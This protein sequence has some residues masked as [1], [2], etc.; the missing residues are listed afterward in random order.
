MLTLISGFSFSVAPA[1]ATEAGIIKRG[2]AV[3]TGFSGTKTDKDVP[4]DVHPLDRTFINLGGSSAQIFDLSVL[5][6]G[7]RGQ[8]ADVPSKLQIKAADVGQVF[9][10]T[11]DDGN[12]TNAPNAYLTATSL[13]GLNLVTKSASGKVERLLKGA[14]DAAWM[15]GQF[16][17]DKGGTPGSVWKVD[18]VTGAT[19][20][21]ATIKTY[22]N[23]NAGAGLGNITFDPK[24]RLLFVSDLESGMIHS[25]A[26]NGKERDIFDH[27][28]NGRKSQGLDPIAFDETRRMDITSPSFN[29]EDPA[30]WGY[31]D[32]RRRTF[33]VAVNAGRLY[34]SVAEGP[35]VWSVSIDDDGDFGSDARIELEVKD[36]ASAISDILFDGSGMLFLS[37]RGN[38][39]GSYDY[40]S[41]AT[42]QQS[43]VLRYKWDAKESRWAAVPDEYA[44]GMAKDFR[45]TQGGIASNYGYDKFGNIDFGKCRQTLW[46]TGEHLRELTGGVEKVSSGGARIVHGLQ[47]NY[48]S[49][50]RPANEPPFETWFTDYDGRDG[51]KDAFGHIGDVAIFAPCNPGAS[52]E[53]S[54]RVE[55]AP[56]LI[57]VD[58]PVDVPGLIINKHCLPGAIGGMIRCAITVTN[59][60][61]ALPSEDVK[62]RDVTRTLIGPGA[63]AIV[64]IAAYATATPAILCSSVPSL[65]FACTI[66]ALLLAPGLSSGFDVFIDTHDL[67]IAGN[68]GF[69]NCA[70]IHHPDGWAKACS[71]GGTDIVVEKIGPGFCLPGAT[72][73][74]GLKIANMGTM[75]FDG[76][77]LLAD[78]MFVGG[79]VTNAPV[80][81]V[82]PPIACLAGNT[83]QLPFTCVSHLSLL[84]GE[85]H[86]HWV[87]VTM[88]AP[89]GYWA[90]NCFGALDPSLVPVGP[91]P[92]GLGSG[93][94]GPGNPSCVWVHVPVPKP[95]LKLV[96]TALHGGKC[97]KVGADLLCDYEIK[98][99]N[100]NNALFS[101][102]VKIEETVPA[103][104][105]IS[106]VSAPWACAG[107]P[108]SYTCDTGALPVNIPAGGSV[109]FNVTV[110]IPVAVSEASLC[111]VPNKAKIQTPAGG[112]A[113]NIDATDDASSA[114]AWTFGLFWED[115]ITHIT[116]VMCDPTNLRV[117]KTAKGPCK[118]SG[119][120]FACE[121][122]VTVTNTGP[123]P[124]KGPVRLDEK[125][126]A[127]PSNVSFDGDFT[128]SG[129]GADYNCET[130]IVALAKGASLTLNVKSKVPGSGVCALPNTATMTFP[131]VGSKGN[132]KGDD[133]S[134]SATANVPSRQ[135][136]KVET[137]VPP[138]PQVNRS[139]DGRP[140]PR[141]GK[142]PCTDGGTWS[143]ETNSCDIGEPHE[144]KGCTP[145]VNEVK[146]DGRCVCREGYW[147]NDGRCQKDD[148]PKQPKGC[149]PGPHEYRNDNGRCVCDDGFER[150]NDGRCVKDHEEPQGCTPG[151]HEYK[152]PK[153]RCVC[154]EGYARADNGRCVKEFEEPTPPK[155]CD[156]GP[157]ESKA[158]NGRCNCDD[159]YSR[160]DNGRCVKDHSPADDCEAKGWNWTGKRCVPPADPGQDCRN[161]GG[162]WTG[163][164]CVW[165]PK[166]PPPQQKECPEGTHGKY[167]KC[168]PDF[169]PPPKHKE[170]DDGT[171]G[172]WPNCKRDQPDPP[173]QPKHCPRGMAGEPPEC[174]WPKKQNDDDAPP[175]GKIPIEIFKPK[176]HNNNDG[177]DGPSRP[178]HQQQKPGLNLNPGI[179]KKFN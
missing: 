159:G 117:E 47:G 167:P 77:L 115:P 2:D 65:D 29:S 151:P 63:G 152:S 85:E 90:E 69:R 89:G 83:T 84:P 88:P 163:S 164:K 173:T 17:F 123:D 62:V 138:P 100:E 127:A 30:T 74:F 58:P 23:D 80:T 149:T 4:A 67:A 160:A 92:P 44:I 175:K 105:G 7:P 145:G 6:T 86:L 112:I 79:A 136:G 114:D 172:K 42:P 37:Q 18:G 14:P 82:N 33:G 131:P 102:P 104:A 64:P 81:A 32:A 48:K 27:G 174:W 94:A 161:D 144:P 113:P 31:A 134:A 40:S 1:H 143:S 129:G 155:G 156:P 54:T 141:S 46:S 11:L 52:P 96:K 68:I 21:F 135:C 140:I 66:P 49:R 101:G 99:T 3:V 35:S 57:Y 8:V 9:G 55:T 171:H 93:G 120:D 158:D 26:L 53:P 87:D 132:G 124:Y 119:G 121:Y 169:V 130:P 22:G 122:A 43:A 51:D 59:I 147:N 133:D 139:P 97:A 75:P 5:G 95:N 91:V 157:H 28:V 41:F 19:S 45:G 142:C 13:F 72:C 125:F 107:G 25:I 73:K 153:G 148:E 50:V 166:D 10:L 162:K 16:A 110:K 76:D 39:A 56:P 20:L 34:Y 98:L 70:S 78:A 128:C 154:D 12:G 177:G 165:P 61:A 137:L 103:G 38:G 15:P 179:F 126:G 118:P 106:A 71:E 111:V 178:Q 36:Q 24:S 150:N 168:S 108:P 176:H 116:F 109:A 60:G 170:C 146:I